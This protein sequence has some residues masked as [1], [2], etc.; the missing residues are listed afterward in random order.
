MFQNISKGIDGYDYPLMMTLTKPWYLALSGICV[1]DEYSNVLSGIFVK[2]VGETKHIKYFGNDLSRFKY[3]KQMS[4]I[5]LTPSFY[6][7]QQF[8]HHKVKPVF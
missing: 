2:S 4:R 5:S 8:V 3:I 1:H 6:H 7:I